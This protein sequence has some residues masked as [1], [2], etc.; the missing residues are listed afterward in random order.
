MHATRAPARATRL[1]GGLCRR[2]VRRRVGVHRAGGRPRVADLRYP[3]R[4]CRHADPLLLVQ[5]TEFAVAAGMAQF[6]GVVRELAPGAPPAPSV[7]PFRAADDS[8]LGLPPSRA[9]AGGNSMFEMNL[10]LLEVTVH[11]CLIGRVRAWC[12]PC[13]VFEA[14]AAVM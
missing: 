8:L 12:D 3:G 4:F 5:V 14:V 9:E 2:V 1:T 13:T 10:A 11:A 7:T 6:L